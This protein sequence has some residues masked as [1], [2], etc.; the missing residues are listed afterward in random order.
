MDIQEIKDLKIALE[1]E[2]Y[3]AVNKFQ[4][5]TKLTTESVDLFYVDISTADAS[6]PTELLERVSVEVKI[7]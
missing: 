6:H 3:N 1:S 7:P 2:I 4:Q 5:E